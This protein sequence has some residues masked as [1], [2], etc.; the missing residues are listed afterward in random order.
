MLPTALGKGLGSEGRAPMA[1]AV[2][3]G[4]I[5]STILTLVVVPVVYLGI[6]RF[7]RGMRAVMTRVF[8]MEPKVDPVLISKS[9][10]DSDSAAAE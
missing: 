8:R 6:E 9:A 1:V 3:G 2:I 10:P 5:S 4:V 7:R